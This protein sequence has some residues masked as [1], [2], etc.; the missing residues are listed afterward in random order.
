M[1]YPPRNKIKHPEFLCENQYI[2]KELR[3]AE[4]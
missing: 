4:K 1:K 3:A 2:K